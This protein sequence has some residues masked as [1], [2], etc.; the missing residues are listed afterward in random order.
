MEEV[1]G[2]GPRRHTC[3]MSGGLGRSSRRG[4]TLLHL[5]SPSFHP[6]GSSHPGQLTPSAT[7][8]HRDATVCTQRQTRRHTAK[9]PPVSCLELHLL[10][11]AHRAPPEALLFLKQKQQQIPKTSACQR[12]RCDLQLVYFLLCYLRSFIFKFLC[13]FLIE[14]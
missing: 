7:G 4:V 9:R 10:N 13:T 1:G 11:A 5:T 14:V 6:S 8:A 12:G 2:A 3:E